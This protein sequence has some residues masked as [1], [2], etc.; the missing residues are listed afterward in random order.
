MNSSNEQ[1]NVVLFSG[2]FDPIHHGHCEYAKNARELAGKDGLVYAIVNNDKQA[3]MKKGFSFVPQEDRVAVVSS[4][5]YVNKVFLSIDNDRTVCKTIQHICDTEEFKPTHWFNEGDVTS[6][7]P[8]PE[9]DVCNMNGIKIVYGSGDKVQS[10][11]WIL[12]KSVE[13]AYNKLFMS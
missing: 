9:E 12:K 6:S 5:K 2:Y 7:N 13:V 10:S 4:L 3:I 11:S 8:C 1:K